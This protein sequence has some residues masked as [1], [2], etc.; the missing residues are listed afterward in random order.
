MSET[1]DYPRY[2]QCQN[3]PKLSQESFSDDSRF[4]RG[5]CRDDVDE[6]GLLKVETL[7]APDLSC[8]W[9]DHSEPA[10]VRYRERGEPTDGCYSFSLR[11]V[12]HDNLANAVHD[13]LC[14]CPVENYSHCELRTLK[15]DEDITYEPE[16]RRKHSKSATQ[17]KR[18]LNWRINLRNALVVELK[19]TDST[20]SV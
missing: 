7:Q 4:Y 10:D 14:D 6:D 2:L 17:K 5:F 19:P 11:D 3:R 9:A 13:P 12:R 15:S 16:K 18:R 20:D 1:S 8:N